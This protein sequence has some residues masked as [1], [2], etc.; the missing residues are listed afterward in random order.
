MLTNWMGDDG[1]VF[2]TRFE[3][4][5]F[6]YLGDVQW[7]TGRVTDK[8][9]EGNLDLV[10]IEMACTNQRGAQTTLGSASVLLPSRESGPVRLPDA[11]R[12]LP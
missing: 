11:P 6:N 12:D 9:R 3:F 8:R 5:Q 7:C 2:K 4:R 10:E 1:F